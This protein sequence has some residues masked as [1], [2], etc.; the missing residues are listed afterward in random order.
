MRELC[1]ALPP[2][3]G[4]DVNAIVMRCLAKS[5]KGRYADAGGAGRPRPRADADGGAG[6]GVASICLTRRFGAVTR[7]ASLISEATM[8]QSRPVSSRT[9]IHSKKKSAKASSKPRSAKTRTTKTPARSR[10]ARRG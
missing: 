6:G 9:P 5:P 7:Y 10:A 1:D 3:V 4:R 2:D 8:F